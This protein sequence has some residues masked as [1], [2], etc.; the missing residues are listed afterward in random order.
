MDFG[1]VNLVSPV[2]LF[3]DTV[4]ANFLA[5]TA[6]LPNTIN[7]T[8]SMAILRY[9][10]L[11]SLSAYIK[12]VKRLMKT[13]NDSYERIVCYILAQI[14]NGL[15]YMYDSE[16]GFPVTSINA[17][18][19]LVATPCD[20]QEK[21]IVLNSHSRSKRSCMTQV[22]D[23]CQQVTDLLSTFLT[24]SH[25][26]EVRNMSQQN[27]SRYTIGFQCIQSLLRD[28]TTVDDMIT[29]RNVAELM[30]W[31]PKSSDLMLLK[32]TPNSELAC[33][34]WLETQRG[35]IVNR[36]AV[37]DADYS[38]EEANYIKFLCAAT[39]MMVD[40]TLRIIETGV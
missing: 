10:S 9:T 40:D 28:C 13:G 19:V 14:L 12:E 30:L 20:S 23:V 33:S 35:V 11:V 6:D 18:N 34:V 38:I 7:V 3:V 24:A 2:H 15:L 31:G 25:T 17:R 1:H 39:G 37:Q 4:S 27:S 32:G 26:S 22:S 29:A 16:T 5:P 21:I 8:T 36:F